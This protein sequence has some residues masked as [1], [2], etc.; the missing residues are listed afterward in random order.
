MEFPVSHVM[1]SA[2]RSRPEGLLLFLGRLG[3]RDREN[4]GDG[5]AWGAQRKQGT[6]HH[7]GAPRL[8]SV[9]LAPLVLLLVLLVAAGRVPLAAEAASA[10]ASHS[11]VVLDDNS[12]KCWGENFHG[13]LGQPDNIIRGFN[14][15]DMGD[16]LPTVPL[17]TFNAATVESGSEF[18]CALSLLGDVKCWG[19][20][21]RGQ[22]GV[23]NN[24]TVGGPSDVYGMGVNLSTV[25]L[26]TD[27]V[28]D[29]ISVAGSQACALLVNGKLKVSE[30]L[31]VVH[32]TQNIYAQTAATTA[33]VDAGWLMG[34]NMFCC[35]GFWD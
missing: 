10:G 4:G 21:E 31:L 29:K 22:L 3:R 14:D 23:G 18:N 34:P 1:V 15:T 2:C 7:R 6:R 19:R 8:L 16:N 12:I 17:G 24:L 9:A 27:V 33:T 11:C 5:S 13:Q 35:W 25:N 28:V 20:N 30:E 26:G 32:T